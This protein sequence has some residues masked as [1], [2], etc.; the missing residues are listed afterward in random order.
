MDTITGVIPL[1]DSLRNDLNKALDKETGLVDLIMEIEIILH[2][3][4]PIILSLEE[5]SGISY[6][7]HSDEISS[8][9]KEKCKFLK[10]ALNKLKQ[11]N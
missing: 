10:K 8:A 3:L 6:K 5:S 7:I 4:T 9:L 2:Y 1:W 11:E